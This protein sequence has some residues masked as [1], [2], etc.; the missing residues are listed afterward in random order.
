MTHVKGSLRMEALRRYF[1]YTKKGQQLIQHNDM[2][3]ALA[4]E[5]EKRAKASNKYYARKE[6]E[7]AKRDAGYAAEKEA[8][9]IEELR[10][11]ELNNRYELALQEPGIGH[12]RGPVLLEEV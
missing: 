10:R 9:R 3:L 12:D 8:R 4:I 2:C 1:P 5:R 6:R 11:L 7:T